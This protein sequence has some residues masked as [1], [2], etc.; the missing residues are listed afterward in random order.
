M[1]KDSGF[2]PT[3]RAEA[4][5]ACS[6]HPSQG[7]RPGLLI[8]RRYAAETNSRWRDRFSANELRQMLARAR[9][10]AELQ[11]DLI[12]ARRESTFM[13]WRRIRKRCRSCCRFSIQSAARE[14]VNDAAVNG[15]EADFES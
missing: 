2:M 1:K 15:V 12:I 10:P 3:D 5:I 8:L 11:P 7:L 13:R 4:H 9:R 6:A 14:I